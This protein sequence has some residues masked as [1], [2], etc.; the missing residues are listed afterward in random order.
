MVARPD[1]HEGSVRCKRVNENVLT[2]D[3]QG[4]LN[5]PTATKN[6]ITEDGFF[7]TGDVT[8]RDDEGFYRIVDRAK[9]LIKYKVC[10][11][12]ETRLLR[13]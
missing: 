6:S 7:K 2:P 5:N 10:M 12:L 1:N 9:E 4:Y 3:L 11:V 8:I 13:F